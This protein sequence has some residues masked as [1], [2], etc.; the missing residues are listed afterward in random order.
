M[1]NDQKQLSIHK[2]INEW[3]LGFELGNVVK[4]VVRAAESDELEYLKKAK[5]YLDSRIENIQTEA[6]QAQW[7]KAKD[8]ARKSSKRKPAAKKASKPAKAKTVKVAGT[9]APSQNEG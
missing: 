3:G 5:Y 9:P 8:R 2:A 1:A 6:K 7:R 4:N